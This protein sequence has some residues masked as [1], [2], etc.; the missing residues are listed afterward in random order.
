MYYAL[1]ES[2]LSYE[3][4]I[5]G[6]LSETKL[7]ALQRLQSRARLII[8]NAKIKDRWSCSWLINVENIIC[9]DRNMMTYKIINK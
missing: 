6:S 8:E 4:V 3:D 9:Y 1:V 2:H 5:C 7:A